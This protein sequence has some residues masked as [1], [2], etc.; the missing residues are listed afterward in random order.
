M[1]LGLE[2]PEE[3]LANAFALAARCDRVKG[4][5]VGRTIFADAAKAWLAGQMDDA[6]AVD[7]MAA[8]FAHLVDAW[9]RRAGRPA[10]VIRID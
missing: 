4:F 10:D 3:D 2:A 6:A 9:S 8:R 5:A 1:L 7:E